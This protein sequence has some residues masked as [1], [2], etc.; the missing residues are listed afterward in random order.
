MLPRFLP[1][2][3]T[4]AFSLVIL[5]TGFTKTQESLVT[6]TSLKPIVRKSDG[7]CP[8]T[9]RF[10]GSITMNGPGTVK[11]TFTRSDGATGPVST[12]EF[13][14]P[15]TQA[16]STDWTL[17]DANSLPSYAGWQTITILSPNQLESSRDAGAFSLRCGPLS[18]P[19][20]NVPDLMGQLSSS[21]DFKMLRSGLQGA[22]LQDLLRSTAPYT[23]FAPTDQAFE[24]LPKKQ[25]DA[26]LSN[27]QYFK[28]FILR[29]LVAGKHPSADLASGKI[30]LLTTVAGQS[31]SIKAD[32]RAKPPRIVLDNSSTIINPDLFANNSIVHAIDAPFASWSEPI[33]IIPRSAFDG[34]YPGRRVRATEII[35]RYRDPEG[36]IRP[37]LLERGIEAA[38]R[39]PVFDVRA[40]SVTPLDDAPALFV[41]AGY[42]AQG[43][44]QWL[45][46]GPAPLIE[47]GSGRVDGQCPYVVGSFGQQ[48]VD[49]HAA[50]VPGGS[51]DQDL[52]FRMVY[53]I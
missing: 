45:E 28:A 33:D 23:L 27:P 39:L 47:R 43:P 22:K 46:I 1:V 24:K 12:L 17:G 11:Y 13:K 29:H 7:P 4:F 34:K 35:A 44:G 52:H 18:Q 25:L 5:S 50:Y 36:R 8:V 2:I 3:I 42:A 9:I 6:D 19:P 51:C 41:K 16:V 31:I 26:L 10:N 15:G 37:D 53:G 38:Q 21:G 20:R 14:A 48:L 40:A 49:E 32:Q 30:P